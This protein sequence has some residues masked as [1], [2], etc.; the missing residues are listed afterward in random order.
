MQLFCVNAYAENTDDELDKLL[1]EIQAP[2]ETPKTPTLTQA[3]V[4]SELDLNEPIEAPAAN[5]TPVQPLKKRPNIRNYALLEKENPRSK[6]DKDGFHK[7]RYESLNKLNQQELT[8]APNAGGIVCLGPDSA[9]FLGT[10][11]A[12]G[13]GGSLFSVGN[14]LEIDFTFFRPCNAGDQYVTLDTDS[15]GVYKITG[16][17]EIVDKAIKEKRCVAKVIKAYDMVKRGSKVALPI[18]LA[19]AGAESTAPMQAGKVFKIHTE[20]PMAG[21]GDRVCVVFLNQMAPKA[22]TA[23][24]FYNIKDP[25]NGNEIDPYIVAKGKLI[26]SNGSYGTALITSANRPITKDLTVTT[27]F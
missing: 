5:Y 2:T 22:G 19:S 18:Q 24:Y 13:K 11:L 10:V 14:E 15:I 7:E 1:D 4:E 16:L 26:H 21:E 25:L 20:R 6:F 9:Q 23:V 27:R 3:P 17:L 8:D 12:S